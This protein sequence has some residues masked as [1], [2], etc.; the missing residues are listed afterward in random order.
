MPAS[1]FI[2]ADAQLC[3]ASDIM[4]SCWVRPASQTF[5]ALGYG[6]RSGSDEFYNAGFIGGALTTSGPRFA[7]LYKTGVVSTNTTVMPEIGRWY[8]LLWGGGGYWDWR[9]W[10]NGTFWSV[11]SLGSLGQFMRIWVGQPS[12]A[13][14]NMGSCS[15]AHVAI[16]KNSGPSAPLSEDHIRSLAAGASPLAIVPERLIAY[17][18]CTE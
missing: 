15:I 5:F 7:E 8:H 11:A 14:S 12:T 2:Q 4:F 17:F 10:V 6:A 1:A 16:W 9:L 3:S 18:P 13:Q